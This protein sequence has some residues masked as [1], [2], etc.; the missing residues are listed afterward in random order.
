MQVLSKF[1]GFVISHPYSYD[2]NHRNSIVN[3]RQ[4]QLRNMLLPPLDVKSVL[5]KSLVEK[6]VVITVPWIVQYLSML[7]YVTLRLDYYRDLFCV[8]FELYIICNDLNISS[9][10]KF[11]L[12]TCLG[13][14]FDHPNV[15]AEYYD[16]RQNRQPLALVSSNVVEV[17]S[18]VEVINP[19]MESII[20]AAC[21]FLCDLRVSIMPLW[22]KRQPSRTGHYRHITT[23]FTGEPVLTKKSTPADNQTKLLEAF[24]QSQSLSMR[25]IIE[26]G[27]ERV[28]SAA[29]KDF[30]F[31]CLLVKKK[32]A[33][34]EV[35]KLKISD[36]VKY[37]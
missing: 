30:Q 18:K 1:I 17:K 33:A 27:I 3:D 26:F 5:L 24:L 6:K 23:R 21:P 29:I 9:T 32:E 22:R 34:Q 11:I 10:T 20:V 25:K 15:P 35:R 4:I 28:T 7:D 8:L 2:G 37:G 19:L 14:L 36:K 12:R 31:E 13:W 16:Y